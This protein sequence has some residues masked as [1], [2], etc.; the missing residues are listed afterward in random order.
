[1][2]FAGSNPPIPAVQW[3]HPTYVHTAD[4]QHRKY[5]TPTERYSQLCSSTKGQ[6]LSLI[7]DNVYF[8]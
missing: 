7:N 2:Y 1:M 5:D 6:R 8:F 3:R 4:H